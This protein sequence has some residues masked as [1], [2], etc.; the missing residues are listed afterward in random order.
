MTYTDIL[1]EPDAAG[2]VQVTI[3]RPLKLNALSN[4]VMAELDDAFQRVEREYRG[5][6]LTGAGER[7]F[8]GPEP[9][10]LAQAIGIPD[11]DIR[12]WIL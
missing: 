6:I 1:F 4:R 8:C 12:Q 2:W 11:R 5:L 9:R 7:R 10:A 3:H